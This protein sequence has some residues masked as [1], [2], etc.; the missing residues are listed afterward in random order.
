MQQT[1]VPQSTDS[2]TAKQPVLSVTMWMNVPSFY[3]QDLQEA[4]VET[5]EVDLSIIYAR[6]LTADRKALGWEVRPISA[7]THTLRT[8]RS[9]LEAMR[10]AWRDRRRIHIV[11]GIW[12][13]PAFFAALLVLRLTRSKYLIYA[14]APEFVKFKG[15]KPPKKG[16]AERIK[17]IGKRT[18]GRWLATGAVGL[19]AISRFSASYF[20]TIGISKDRIFPFGY[21]RKATVKVDSGS[22]ASPKDNAKIDLVFVGRPEPLKGVDLLMEMLIKFIPD[23][24]DLHLT[25]IGDGAHRRNYEEFASQNGLANHVNFLGT[26]PSSQI[27]TYLATMDALVLPTRGDG[28]GIVVNEA[29]SVGIPVI[30]SDQCGAAE[31]I[32]HKVNGYIFHS[33][34]AEDLSRCLADFLGNRE[35]WP[36]MRA[37]AYETGQKISADVAARYLVQILRETGS[38]NGSGIVSMKPVPPWLKSPVQLP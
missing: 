3:Q 11:S 20:A 24:P 30:V 26:R 8:P 38:K 5:K 37:S 15:A 6:G 35:Q 27:P 4:L 28:W 9:I 10:L 25:L 29:L 34:D 7:P 16:V 31:L 21:F 33:G 18:L 19:L 1:E 12:A 22:T 14:E 32:Q 23:Y 17:A 36:K 13:E 2:Q